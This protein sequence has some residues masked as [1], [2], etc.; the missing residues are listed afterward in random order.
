MNKRKLHHLWTKLRPVSYWYFFVLFLVSGVVAVFAMRDNNIRSLELRNK[1]VEVDEANDDVEAALKELRVHI[2]SHM[3]AGLAVGEG[4]IRPPIQLKYRYERLVRAEKQRV[5]EINEKVYT[6]AQIY[7][8]Q[9]IPTGTIAGRVPCVQDYVS[10]NTVKEQPIPD[11]LY[12]FDFA[13]PTWSPDLA[14]WS[15]V[16][17]GIFGL[18]TIF[19]FL[20][21][22]Y[23]KHSLHQHL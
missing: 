14:G 17:T 13:S 16:A 5:S 21:E 10:K 8:E 3:N 20:L 2:H 4:S 23:L 22:K 15:L 19:R 9:Q 12:K 6:D 18:L 1:V 7:C 11:A